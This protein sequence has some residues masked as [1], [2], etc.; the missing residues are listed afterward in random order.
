MQ[1]VVSISHFCGVII[2]YIALNI[3]LLLLIGWRNDRNKLHALQ[4]MTLALGIPESQIDNPENQSAVFKYVSDKFS[5][6]RL[7]N[8]LSDFLGWIEIAWGWLGIVVQIVYFTAIV[9]STVVNDLSNSIYVWWT[10]PI[11]IFFWTVSIVFEFFCKV[12][13]GRYPGQARQAMKML[14]SATL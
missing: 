5:S 2:F 3:G 14:A 8:R 6:E 11:A 4:E 9:W 7:Y 13:I 12:L 10:I 1:I